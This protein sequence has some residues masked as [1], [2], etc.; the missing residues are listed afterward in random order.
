[1][2]VSAWLRSLGLEQYEGPFREN[3]ID[4]NVLLDL[5]AEDLKEL[6][7][8][9]IGH[10][11]K[12]LG[13]I[14]A[15]RTIPNRDD[16]QGEKTDA[17]PDDPSAGAEAGTPSVE[18]RQLTVLFCDLVG[19]AALSRTLDPEDMR[20]LLRAYQ[21]TVAGEIR[22]FDGHIAQFLGDGVVAYF[23][24]PR[25][26]EDDAERGV[27]AG[28]AI[29]E[30]I[31][32]LR[33]PN[34]QPVAVRIAIAT[35]LVVSGDIVGEGATK[36]DAVVGDTPNLAAHLQALAEPNAI[37]IA[38]STRRLV[39]RAFDLEALRPQT[40]KGFSEPVEVWRVTG[41]SKVESRFEAHVAGH[42]P[43]IGRTQEVALLLARWQQACDGEGQVV[44]LSGEPGIGKSRI[45][46]ALLE[47][48][49]AD[50][51]IR[52]RN[53]CS[54]YF[55]STALHP[56]IEQLER[57]AGFARN[58]PAPAKLDKLE[59][60]LAK[61]TTQVGDAA[62]LIAALLSIPTEGRYPALTYTPQRQKE[63]TIKVLVDQL[64]GLAEK[65]P[66]LSIFEDVHWADP[67]TLEVIEQIIDRIDSARVLL[68]VTFRPEFVPPWK[69][70]SSITTHALPRLGRRQSATLVAKM[71]GGK[72]LPT[73]VL[74]QIVA[75]T[76]GVPLFVEELTKMVLEAGFLREEADRYVLAGPLPPLAIPSTLQDS[77]MARLDRLA[78]R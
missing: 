4:A 22:R 65:Q 1:M 40:L 2:D 50:P 42:T 33:T 71:T 13:A 37:L 8:T 12:L 75:K 55:T 49:E 56:I 47:Q 15:L 58:D 68:L 62:P 10:R 29:V 27:R 5:T 52:V 46:R 20:E 32:R 21:I 18:R 19:S 73:E 61:G 25:A 43:M 41:A 72:E 28:L 60:L 38:A 11:R 24:F 31:P 67:T 6:G 14:A 63:L 39:G 69:S 3:D 48:V 44:L 7:V 77:L 35:G 74:D 59:V 16:V 9:S 26:H 76:D 78:P 36:E 34:D 23:G 53:Q 45:T 57:A 30:T 17:T 54:P 64:L 70:R 51:H 66:T